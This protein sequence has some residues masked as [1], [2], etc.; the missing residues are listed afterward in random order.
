M[1]S[2][3][4]TYYVDSSNGDDRWTGFSPTAAWRS[5]QRVNR[6]TLRGGDSVLFRRGC[7]WRGASLHGQSGDADHGHIRFGAWGD[8]SAA[9]PQLLGSVSAA[10]PSDW[11]VV[12]NGVWRANLTEL[13]ERAGG[14]KAQV[15]DVGNIILGRGGAPG[16]ANLTAARKV[17][18]ASELA[19]PADFFYNFTFSSRNIPDA[20][21]SVLFLSPHGN[22]AT[23]FGGFV[24]IAI[25]T[26]WHA[27]VT[28][29]GTSFAV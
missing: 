22:P 11:T 13:W 10:K 15:T 2:A 21:G 24:E 29:R 28:N 5:I 4:R 20:A 26:R 27:V 3:G 25:M 9:K 14:D 12:R 17:W 18:A 7:A 8:A 16:E 23:V 1:Q 19:R 6:E